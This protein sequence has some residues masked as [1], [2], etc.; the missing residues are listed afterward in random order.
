MFYGIFIDKTLS[1]SLCLK[2]DYSIGKQCERWPSRDVMIAVLG[3]NLSQQIHCCYTTAGNSWDINCE[4]VATQV[5]VYMP[6][7]G[8][9]T[10][11]YE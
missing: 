4:A 2:E 7:E 6:R 11:I 5:L 3:E 1:L 9:R 10:S 8:C